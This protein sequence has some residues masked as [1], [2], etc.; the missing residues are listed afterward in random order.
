MAGL[1]TLRLTLEPCD[2]ALLGAALGPRDAPCDLP[3]DWP[4]PDALALFEAHLE[5]L[6]ADPSLAPWGPW[7]L[8]EDGQLVGDA[9]FKGPPDDEG[10]VELSYFVRRAF[11]GRGLATEAVAAL[12]DHAFAM[13]ALLVRGEC[14]RD[15]R[16]SIGVLRSTGF[17]VTRIEDD[18]L[19]FERARDD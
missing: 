9:G 18:Q 10:G 1:R 6:A 14:H 7:L 5:A 13:G 16:A 15:N 12:V 3:P 11:R 8:R 19:R 2:A 4:E 17:H